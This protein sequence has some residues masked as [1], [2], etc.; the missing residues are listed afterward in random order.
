MLGL[1]LLNFDYD[2]A[3]AK[4]LLDANDLRMC[5]KYFGVPTPKKI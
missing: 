4:N 5:E 1:N 2:E 3:K